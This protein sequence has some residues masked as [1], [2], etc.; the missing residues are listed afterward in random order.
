MLNLIKNTGTVL[1]MSST[2]EPNLFR[3]KTQVY[4]GLL[5]WDQQSYEH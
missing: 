2:V 3:L 5:L 1:Q 4:H